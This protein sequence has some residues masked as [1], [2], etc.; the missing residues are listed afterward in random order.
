VRSL[1]RLFKTLGLFHDGDFASFCRRNSIGPPVTSKNID[2]YFFKICDSYAKI[3]NA[4]C[5]RY[6]EGI[7]QH[8][9][10]DMR[11][12]MIFCVDNR[13][14]AFATK[15]V[16]GGYLIGINTGTLTILGNAYGSLFSESAPAFADL[17]LANPTAT[18]KERVNALGAVALLSAL[19]F[20]FNHELGHVA[21]GHADLVHRRSGKVSG[22]LLLEGNNST[23][24]RTLPADL[25]QVME[26]DAD[27]HAATTMT[28]SLLRGTLCGIRVDQFMT[29]THDAL[30]IS[31]LAMLIMFHK[32]YGS[33]I[34]ID[35]YR[36]M[37]HPLPE[38]RLMRV[39]SRM[40]QIHASLPELKEVNDTR[41][42][43]F[44]REPPGLDDSQ[45]LISDTLFQSIPRSHYDSLFPS[46]RL[47]R[48][49]NLVEEM[50]RIVT[51]E[52]R[53]ERELKSVAVLEIGGALIER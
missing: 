4:D 36:S 35:Q 21:Y 34:R 29:S 32:F 39:M 3:F 26:I 6:E 1:F 45:Q 15:Y 50:R 52:E 19:H 41:R 37:T 42:Y 31:L 24:A 13:L 30:K 27:V 20:L 43:L 11:I 12:R 49:V 53:Y 46:L 18:P 48:R 28:A 22:A 47:E 10:Q 17:N 14:N 40:G 2:P 33:E 8:A 9:E 25:Y 16:D 38:L 23:A 51:N 7:K 5:V 44:D